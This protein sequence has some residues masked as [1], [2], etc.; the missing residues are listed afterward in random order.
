MYYL[1]PQDPNFTSHTVMLIEFLT[2]GVIFNRVGNDL[3]ANSCA[4]DGNVNIICGGCDETHNPTAGAWFRRQRKV[5]N[6]TTDEADW[7]TQLTGRV[8]ADKAG[9]FD[10]AG[11]VH[12]IKVDHTVPDDLV[13]ELIAAVRNGT[14][15]EDLPL[16][17]KAYEVLV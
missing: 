11:V 9:L 7:S 1:L 8:A 16:E 2:Q 3:C 5:A 6:A 10:K 14:M 4:A 13:G 17:A 12:H 15:Y